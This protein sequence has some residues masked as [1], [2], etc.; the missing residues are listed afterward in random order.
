MNPSND[1]F[2]QALYPS[3]KATFSKSEEI[4]G[5]SRLFP[6]RKIQT[7]LKISSDFAIKSDREKLVSRNHCEIYTVVYEPGINHIY[8]RD[9]KS[10]NGTYVNK[11]L[12]GQGPD[13]CSGFLLQDGDIIEILPYWKFILH[14]ENSPPSVELSKIQLAESR[15]RTLSKQ[16]YDGQHSLDSFFRTNIRFQDDVSDKE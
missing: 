16:L 6:L 12:V 7:K 4:P 11:L 2:T 1:G 13:L 9:R 5:Q 8:V 3:E 14:Q 10:F 15:V